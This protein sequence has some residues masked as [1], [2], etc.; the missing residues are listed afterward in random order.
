VLTDALI[1]ACPNHMSPAVADAINFHIE[2]ANDVILEA[3]A[4]MQMT[5]ADSHDQVVACKSQMQDSWKEAN[6][7]EIN[8]ANTIPVAKRWF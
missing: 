8:G 2:C 7:A 3:A 4:T 1:A 5:W 6:A